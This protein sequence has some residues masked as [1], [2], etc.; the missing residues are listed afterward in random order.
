MAKVVI[1]WRTRDRDAIRL[2]R[3]KFGIPVYTTVNGITPADIKNEDMTMFEETAR[4][5][6]FAFWRHNWCIKG[7]VLVF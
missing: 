4:C 3:E 6:F 1:N 2:I 5:G 7:G